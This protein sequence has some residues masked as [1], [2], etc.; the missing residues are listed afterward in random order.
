MNYQADFADFQRHIWFNTASEGPLPKIAAAALQEAVA[1]KSAP[2]LLGLDKFAEVPVRLK[3]ALGAMIGA[4][5]RDIILGNS[6]SYGVHLLANGLPLG[7]GD[8]V[9]L[10]QNDFPTDILP[11]LALEKKGVRIRQIRARGPIITP[12]EIEEAATERA[13]VVCLAQVHSFSGHRLD[14]ARVAEICRARGLRLILNISQSAGAEPVDV[15]RLGAHAVIAAGYKWL[16]GPYGTGFAWMTPELRGTLDINLNYWTAALSEA[17]LRSEGP[18]EYRDLRS[19]RKY[20][21]FATA[22][23]FNFVPFTASVEYLLGIGMDKVR[24]YNQGLIERFTRGLDRGL[25]RLISPESWPERTNLSVFSHQYPERNAGIHAG[26]SAVGIHLALWKGNLRFSPHLF[27]TTS[28]VDR[29]LEEL[30]R[31][32]D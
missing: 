26:L 8:E 32:A 19:A 5:P 30:G 25:Y 3:R 24:A 13:R 15:G 18:L 21:V 1:W 17:D 22:N 6:A 23:F 31:L 14:V 16:L 4:D 7:P 2:Y 28:E 20:D 27:N 11:W 12:E 9:L 29:L 10:M